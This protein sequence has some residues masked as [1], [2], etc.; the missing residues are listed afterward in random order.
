MKTQNL[1]QLERNFETKIIP[2]LSERDSEDCQFVYE[3]EKLLYDKILKV[4]APTRKRWP[5]LCK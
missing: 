5:V 3:F 2:L 1:R 4:S